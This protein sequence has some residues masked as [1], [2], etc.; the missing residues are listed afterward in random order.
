MIH[1]P[2]LLR[3]VLTALKAEEPGIY[4]DCTVGMGGHAEAI[5][6]Q[7]SS[8]RLIGIDRDLEALALA[9][10][11]LAS[12]GERVQLYHGN[13]KDVGEILERIEVRL[14]RPY[15]KGALF[16]LGV[17][18]LQLDQAGRGF[19]FQKDAF[20]DMR[21]DRTQKLTAF[22]VINTASVEELQEI[23]F[24]WGEER[25]AKPISR[26]IDEAR[27]TG[28][29][30]TTGQLAQIVKSAIPKRFQSKRIHPATKVFQALRIVV[31]RELDFLKESLERVVSFLK[32]GGRL[33]VISF[34]SLEDR[35]VKDTFL[36]LAKGCQCPS[37][38]PTCTCG[39]KPVVKIISN[40]RVKSKRLVQPSEEE[41]EDN[42]RS[43]S[44]K[45]RIAEKKG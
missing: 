23:F 15:L 6:K 41:Q 22:D 37:W 21:M 29:I 2:V 7:N 35:I 1:I 16:D 10:E 3:E 40:S 11:K 5:L 43:R 44:A 24:K 20:L 38:F 45:L 8:N 36:A 42:P 4:L 17:S 19:S 9:K 28:E 30:R 27:K 26:R 25:W 13:Y 14:P 39:R 33:C 18:S 32:P 34:H 12:F 31:N